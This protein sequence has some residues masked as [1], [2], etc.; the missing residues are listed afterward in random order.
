MQVILT[1]SEEDSRASMGLLAQRGY[2]VLLAP[3]LR[4]EPIAAQVGTAADFG[5]IAFTSKRAPRALLRAVPRAVAEGLMGL[6]VFAV[7]AKTASAVRR[8][9]FDNVSVAAGT[10]AD[11]A[12]LIVSHPFDGGVLYAAARERSGD[13]AGDLKSRG[14]SCE[15]RVVYHMQQVYELPKLVLK[16]I[17]EDRAAAALFYS[18]RTAEAF[19]EAC[20][21][22]NVQT[23]LKH[24]TAL[25]IS[26]QV[27]DVCCAF[28]E[29]RI[30]K[31]PD[32]HH[33]LDLLAT[34]S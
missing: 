16:E 5:A 25:C 13:L 17:A 18:K 2:E 22:E 24:I 6:P 29:V 4:E 34:C 30:A 23:E 3:M 20:T 14:I 31:R 9:G 27:A 28:G 1:R 8:S 15:L 33:L 12:D 10:V 19:V 7:G 11:L 26:T 32:E 21:L